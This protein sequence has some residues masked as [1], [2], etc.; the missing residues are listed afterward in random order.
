TGQRLGRLPLVEG[1]PVMVGH[2]YDI[3]GGMV[4]GTHGFVCQIPYCINLETSE[5]EVLSC[6]IESEDVLADP[7]PNLPKQFVVSLRKPEKMQ[8]KN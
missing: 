6:V 8:F 2:N 4:N 7:L 5:R 3:E 1:M